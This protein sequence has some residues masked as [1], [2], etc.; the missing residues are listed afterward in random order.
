VKKKILDLIS[1]KSLIDLT[2]DLVR[3]PSL[4]GEEG[5]IASFLKEKLDKIG[6]CTRIDNHGNLIAIAKGEQKNSKKLMFLGH[7]DVVSPIRKEKWKKD[8]FEPRI[9]DSK[10]YGLGTSD[11]KS[12]LASFLVASEAL[13][14]SNVE[15]AG[16][17]QLVFVVE[18]EVGNGI[19][20]VLK[21]T[22]MIPTYAIVG[23]PSNLQ[24]CLGQKYGVVFNVTTKGKLAHFSLSNQ[25]G[26]DSLEKMLEIINQIKKLKLPS[27]E[28]L[29]KSTIVIPMISVE[30]NEIGFIN[31]TCSISLY[32]NLALNNSSI[33]PAEQ[34][35]RKIENIVEKQRKMNKGF[36]ANIDI[37]GYLPSFYTS[38]EDP[39]AKPLVESVIRNSSLIKGKKP[40]LTYY[41]VN[42]NAGFLSKHN[43]PVVGFGPGNVKNIHMPEEHVNIN[44]IITATKVYALTAYDL[45]SFKH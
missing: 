20:Y 19:E 45:L 11:M 34:M 14:K 16:E 8:P 21:D 7:M 26:I 29:G 44:Q 2:A 35:K 39:K 36:E 1:T 28:Q 32:M 30:P 9:E 38:P 31:D 23:E 42:T 12:A 4:S 10:I 15:L 43:V 17:L 33:K 37:F 25:N 27:H 6:F 18:E 5:T 40:K 22:G 41:D 13:L 24:V 3:I